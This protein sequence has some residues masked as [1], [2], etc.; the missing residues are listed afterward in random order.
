MAEEL[1]RARA[2]DSEA[3]MTRTRV[4]V[5]Q[6]LAEQITLS[7]TA[8]ARQARVSKSFVSKHFGRQIAESRAAAQA[9][10]AP[11]PTDLGRSPDIERLQRQWIQL[12][13]RSRVEIADLHRE[14]TD[15]RREISDLRRVCDASG[16]LNPHIYTMSDAR[17]FL[18]GLDVERLIAN[19]ELVAHEID[20]QKVF[21]AGVLETFFT[22]LPEAPSENGNGTTDDSDDPT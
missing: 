5:N 11:M 21:K 13:D 22:S 9:T 7:A 19:G 18:G 1:N 8:I 3:K 20:G 2:E 16:K 12:F 17:T 14:I 10:G 15:L 6:Q 4:V